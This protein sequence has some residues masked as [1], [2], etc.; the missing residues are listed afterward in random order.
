MIRPVSRHVAYITLV[1]ILIA[2][3]G[4]RLWAASGTITFT[5]GSGLSAVVEDGQGG[6]VD[7]AGIVVQISNGNGYTWTYETPYSVAGIGAS[8]GDSAPSSLIT[9]KSSNQSANFN[10]KS[11]YLADYGGAPITVAGYD[12]G[13]SRGSVNLDLGGWENTVNQSNGLTASI[14]QNVDEVRITPQS[15]SMMWILL[16]NIQ[17]DDPVL[18]API[19]TSATYNASTGVLA[20]TG[21]NVTS[22]GTIDVSK[23]TLTGEGGSTYTLTTSNVTASSSTSFSV[24]LNATDKSAIN[25]II[26]RNGTSSSSG[27]T[28]NLAAATNWDVTASAAADLTGNGVT[29]SNVAVPAITSATYDASTGAL[30]VTGTGFSSR[31]GATNDIVAN[32]FTFTGEGGST[33]TLTDTANVEIT[34]GTSLALT[35]SATD[36]AAVNLLINKNGTSSTGGTTYNLAAAE[37]WAAGADA[38]VVVA[39]LTGNG[40]TVSNVAAPTL[41]SS[42]YN[43][44]TGA[45]VVT[46]S[47]FLTLSGATNDIV[48]NKFTFTGEGGSTYTLTDTANVEITSGTSF[49][50]ILSATDRAA[51]SLIV[52]KNGTFSTDISTYQLSAAEDWAAGADAAVTVADTS[53][54]G[55]TVSNV[56]VPSITSA[57]YNA[58]T[59]ALVVTGAGFSSRFGATNDIAANK[60]T[61]TGEGGSTYTLTD[62]ANVEITSGS[63]FTLTLSVTDLTTANLILNKNGTSSVDATTYNLAA[64]EDWAA[65]A[66]AAVAVADL[67]GN[68]IT[69]SNANAAPAIG[70]L[71]GDTVSY[72]EGAAAVLIDSGSDAT[73]SDL[74]S[75]DFNGGNLSVA[76]VSNR[77]STED[78]LSVLNQGTGAG[79]IGVSS[80]TVTYGGVGIGTFV[81]GSGTDNLVITLNG[82]ATPAAVQ[83]LVR[84]LTYINSNNAEPSTS[85]RTV[86]VT[87]NDGSGGTGA[88]SD[89]AVTVT[90]VN[91]APTLSATG[92]TP[93]FTEGGSAVDLFSGVSASAVETGQLVTQLTLTASNVANGSSEILTFDGSDVALTNGNVVTTATNSMTVSIFVVGST[94]TVSATRAPGIATSAA[95]T[96]IDS[97]AY[98]NTSD[99]PDT[100]SRIVT[101][102]GLRDSGGTANSGVDTTSLS[103]AATVALAAVNDAPTITAPGV[104]A[105]DEDVTTALLGFSFSDV[106]AG[107]G[108]VSITFSVPAGT[109]AATSGS[110]VTVAG[111]G[112]GTLTLSGTI[113]NL[114]AFLTASGASFTTATN[115]TSN[116]TLTVSIDDA[117]NTGSD[118]GLSGTASSEAASTTVTLGVT[119]VNDSPVNTAP[120]TAA[121]N[122]NASRVFSVAN[123]NAISI[124]DVD[125]GGGTVRVTLT[126]TN[127]LLTLSGTTGLTFITGTGTSDA[128]MTFEGTIAD[129][130]LGLNGLSFA[131]T[132]GYNGAASLQIVTND[133]GLTGSGGA[134]SDTDTVAI[135]VNS[136]SPT[137]T[138]VSATTANGSYKL[139]DSINLTVTFDQSVFANIAGGT[140]TLLLETGATDRTATYVSGTG[141][142]TL[143]FSYTVQAGD[144]SA[145]LDY[146]SSLALV[147][148]GATLQNATADNALLTLPTLGGSGSIAGQK[149]LV[150]DGIVPTVASVLV[151]ANGTYIAGQNLDFVVNFSE[152]VVV[153][154]TGGTPRVLLTLDTGGTVF[155]NYVSGSG[156][157][158]LTFRYTVA[159]G[160]SDSTGI[161]LGASF[162]A[163]GGTIRDAVGNDAGPTLNSVG[164]TTG[165]LV[166][167]II[168]FV[169]SIDRVTA[170]PTSA[171]TL[172]FTVTFSEAVSGVDLA[173]FALTTT[174]SAA[175]TIDNVTVVSPLIYTVALVNVTGDGTLRLDLNASGTGI[176]DLSG[177]AVSGGFTTGQVYSLDHSGPIITSGATASGRYGAAFAGYTITASEPAVFSATGIPGGLVLNG[178][179]IVGTPMQSGSFGIQLSATDANG[180]TGTKTLILTIG[181]ADHSMVWTQPPPIVYG[182]ALGASQLNAVILVPGH[183]AYSPA[184]GTVL[185]PG[186]H[187]LSVRHTPSDPTNNEPTSASVMITVTK[188]PLT[189]TAD[190]KTKT[191]GQANPTLTTTMT[192]FVNGETLATS[193]VTGSPT[194]STS[195]NAS[196][197][198]GTAVIT[199]APGS[200]AAANYTFKMVE[201][202]LTITKAPQTIAFA[203]VDAPAIGSS[204]ALNAT[205]SSGLPVSLSIVSGSATLNGVNLVATA[206]G[207]VMVRASQPGNNDYAAAPDV[208]RTLTIEESSHNDRII[209]LS[210]RARIG[211]TPAR[212]LI[213]GFVIGGSAPKRVL[214]RAVGPG[215]AGFGLADAVSNPRL[216]IYDA[217]GL[218]VLEN[219]DWSGAETSAAFTE[220]GAFAL[221]PGGRDAA[222]V[223]Q[224]APGAYTMHVIDGG[225]T[226]VALAEIYDASADPGAESQRLVNLS[227]RGTVDGGD[228]VLIGGFV[229]TGKTPKR[230]LVRG[231]GPALAGFG[232]TGVLAD[233]RL[234]VFN[235]D[236]LVGE[237]D[238]W[239]ANAVDALALASSMQASGAF[240]LG[241]GSR[242]AAIVLTLQPGAYTAQVSAADASNGVA[243][244]E[245]YEV[246]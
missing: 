60:F 189:V 239:D 245:I 24:T 138:S 23:L 133:L 166:D 28:Y 150:V 198:A 86:R 93:T 113:T 90:G 79:Q 26:N 27:T 119:A 206:A 127:G 37:D 15:G 224:L 92:G 147:A 230:V 183:M 175:A 62:T 227:S 180:N 142:D 126:A 205:A 190:A 161:A 121:T 54:N 2:A 186:T 118:P 238:N 74:D 243:L 162:A 95:Q 122:Q 169:V 89:V 16:N 25:L 204:I 146:E 220:V 13:V 233:P 112:T 130:N 53:G 140:P 104:L 17:I 209:N 35:L 59:G 108:S 182:T 184:A 49:T 229:V 116:V 178:S 1:G 191:F 105:V 4:P 134:R 171:T 115:A 97:L 47:G 181:K 8:Y 38:A 139:G 217:G 240:V 70:G 39:D 174:N 6:S 109:L 81:G 103:I 221:T 36:R 163:N 214:L 159:V 164:A 165:V 73:V 102:T 145:D 237:N 12:D 34:S 114:N 143:A 203:P 98:R 155:A 7:I 18:P 43:A 168:P 52:N 76:I 241:A 231:I 65:G 11:I 50:L 225:P 152:A 88:N 57:T 110:G 55:I 207:P 235:G 100:T 87:L 192:G 3:W 66:D 77:V 132:P 117:G 212:A 101:L 135:T 213:T 246:Q 173:D 194:V 63:S 158:A 179:T 202:V 154:T 211:T 32:K 148:N 30:V 228:G 56:P 234:R 124:A 141:T 40:I 72:T 45:L 20:V 106:D 157:S 172:S 160:N 185:K 120:T 144:V 44:S 29:A 200:L 78:N 22:G 167:A 84:N 193:G 208:T 137:V 5:S 64:A 199:P 196:T 215:L 91:D 226:G 232:V 149:N 129:I 195:A 67:T 156:T 201:G 68:G 111:S 71:H 123:S 21:T 216:Q 187:T 153:D 197:P 10:F 58:S 210:S 177:S 188:A 151:P 31:S 33:Y 222:L 41:T 136:I 99:T 94:A 242:D 107:S 223:A 131:P 51:V 69:V 80:A 125:A 128:T 244:V 176:T 48:A 85:T 14:F 46:G 218:M 42:T 61:F 82:S 19:I 170:T 83:A 9:I 75:A 236:T 219:D 96:L